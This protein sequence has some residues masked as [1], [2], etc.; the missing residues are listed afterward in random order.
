[1]YIFTFVIAPLGY[2]AKVMISRDLS[3]E[4]VWVLY[5]VISLIWIL[6]TYSDF[7]LSE[8]LNFFLPRYFLSKD[9]WRVKYLLFLT[10]MVLICTSILIGWWLYLSAWWIAENYFSRNH[11]EYL[12]L[13]ME[14]LQIMSLFFVWNN[15]LHIHWN[16]FSATQNIIY[17]KW[18][19]LIRLTTTLIWISILFFSDTGNILNYTW[20]W[21]I[22]LGVW[23]F[24]ANVAGF[25]SYYKPY[26]ANTSIIY[27]PI[28][29][30]DFYKYSLATLVTS[31][32]GMFLHQIDMQLIIYFLWPK[33]VWYYSNYLSII[34]IPFM[35]LSPIIGFL[36]PVISELYSKNSI[37]KIG[38]IYAT[39]SKYFT[40]IAIWVSIFFILFGEIFAVALF[41]EQFHES[42][43]ILIYST[44]FLIFNFLLQINFQ[45]LAGTGRIRDRAK[46]LLITIPINLILNL[47]A[48]LIL[49]MWSRWSALAVWLSWI[50][51][52]WMSYRAIKTYITW[53]IDW[54]SIIYN[55]LWSI[56]VL[57]S[58]IF[59]I[60]W[61]YCHGIEYN[62][63][64]FNIG[65][66]ISNIPA[67]FFAILVSMIIF[68]LINISELRFLRKLLSDRKNR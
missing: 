37:D 48:I 46:I 17:Q 26:L 56:A 30:R 16:L 3:V 58:S 23:V 40:I 63:S 7:W 45:I 64:T 27:D 5:G 49:H 52:W 20:V 55:L 54:K 28:L 2:I 18:Y 36:F 29:K 9:Y 42:G 22:G 33:E 39:A 11:P 1:M 19:E 43:R 8:S 62:L 67:I 31:N 25:I 41:W 14:I 12:K 44:P 32:I 66:T 61:Y 38:I 51:L 50:P 4:E 35:L 10:W 59:L 24:F 21:I 60:S 6:S 13:S 47:I 53:K 34:G 68:P 57:S 65:C 15:L